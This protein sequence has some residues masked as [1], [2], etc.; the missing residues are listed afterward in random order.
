MELEKRTL[1]PNSSVKFSEHKLELLDN[2]EN[3]LSSEL[4]ELND[5]SLQEIIKLSPYY[6][7]T[8]SDIDY[9]GKVEMQGKIQKWID[10]SIS[11]TVNMPKNVS[12]ETVEQVYNKAYEVGCKGITVYRE[13][14]RSGVL[15]SDNESKEETDITYHDAP[16]RSKVLKC[17]IY[18][19]TALKQEW[20]VL[21]GITETGKPFEIFAFEQLDQKDFPKEITTGTITRD[22][23]RHYRL[24]GERNGKIY[25]ANNI[26]DLLGND[27][28]KETRKFSSRFYQ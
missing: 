13:G 23:K 20:T 25:E 19:K 21:V 9:I 26:I 28:Q 7:A 6:K 17:D 10:H 4:E 18:N 3:S 8:S 27:E 5:E 12:V 22:K 2:F 1:S 14:S 15:I 11:V 24:T 16:K